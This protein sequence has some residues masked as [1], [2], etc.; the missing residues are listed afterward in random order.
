MAE[1][2]LESDLNLTNEDYSIVMPKAGSGK[3]IFFPPVCWTPK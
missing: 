3:Q 2:Q 1:Q